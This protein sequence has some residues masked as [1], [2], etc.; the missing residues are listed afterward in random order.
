MATGTPTR[1]KIDS[2]F[3]GKVKDVA[4][5]S[6]I[7]FGKLTCEFV[8]TGFKLGNDLGLLAARDFFI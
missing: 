5:G 7:A 4:P 2:K 8:K 1:R 6:V 3:L